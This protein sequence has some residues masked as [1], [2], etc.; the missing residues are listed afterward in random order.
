[1]IENVSSDTD[2]SFGWSYL[3]LLSL[4]PTPSIHPSLLFSFMRVVDIDQLNLKMMHIGTL[5]PEPGTQHS[6]NVC[7]SKWLNLLLN[8]RLWFP[9]VS[10]MFHDFLQS[11]N[12][13]VWPLVQ[14]WVPRFIKCCCVSK[15]RNWL[16]P[17]S[18][19]FILTL[20]MTPP[21]P[22]NINCPNQ[23]CSVTCWS[24]CYDAPWLRSCRYKPAAADNAPDGDPPSLPHKQDA[25]P[26]GEP[27]ARPPSH[28][29]RHLNP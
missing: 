28:V 6:D 10:S 1:M 21:P 3:S 25:Q 18:I 13:I 20:C 19:L 15:L 2:G 16:P 4:Y 24:S 7:F 22:L 11:S 9:L 27:S 26:W 5:S 23:P 17:S 14:H 12:L 29:P 8:T